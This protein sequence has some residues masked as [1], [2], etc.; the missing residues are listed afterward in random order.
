MAKTSPLTLVLLLIAG[1]A[2]LAFQPLAYAASGHIPSLNAKVTALRFFETPYTMVPREKREYANRFGKGEVRFIGW[3]LSLEFPSPGRQVDFP[4]EQVWYRADGTVF[5][6]QT[7]QTHMEAAWTSSFHYQSWGWNNR[8]NWPAGAYRVDLYVGG[9]KAASGSF[10]IV[11]PPNDAIAAY[12]QGNALSR[13]E[14]YHEAIPAYDRA[15]R[16]YPQYAEAYNNRCVAYD[17][18]GKQD[19]AI[20][21]CNRAIQIEPGYADAYG[22]RGAIYSRKG[23]YDQAIADSSKAIEINPKDGLAYSNRGASFYE[24]GEY[25][26]AWQDVTKAQQLGH[27]VPLALLDKL[28]KTGQKSKQLPPASKQPTQQVAADDSQEIT[29]LVARIN[30]HYSR[31]ALEFHW[32]DDSFN[33]DGSIRKGHAVALEKDF[34]L[35]ARYLECLIP[36]PMWRFFEYQSI[37]ADYCMSANSLGDC[38]NNRHGLKWEEKKTSI[39]VA[40][41]KPLSIALPTN[42]SVSFGYEDDS[43]TN[44]FI[45]CKDRNACEQIATDLKKLV[46]IARSS[47][48]P[49]TTSSPAPKPKTAAEPRQAQGNDP[50]EIPRLVQRISQHYKDTLQIHRSSGD[51]FDHDFIIKAQLVSLGEN[52]MLL[53]RYRI[54]NLGWTVVFDN[55][56]ISADSVGDCDNNRHRLK[57]EEETEQVPLIRIKPPSI[58]VLE[59]DKGV[60]GSNLGVS[61]DYEDYSP[62][63]QPDV[64][65]EQDKYSIDID[66]NSGQSGARTGA[67]ANRW[68]QT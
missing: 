61:F 50:Q 67:R 20:A 10:K 34:T 62:K 39:P 30:Q 56:Q 32:P 36:G 47:T 22:N 63:V 45:G 5:A 17:K 24:K 68:R 11:A 55:Y 14:K 8:G 41:L 53:V 44:R 18:L 60:S 26:K 48:A 46:E 40:R 52:F 31:D 2:G 4:I 3:E 23:Q 54:C 13:V 28:R 16:L 38:D 1:A 9:Q 12:N 58:K 59:I 51:F 57:W 35:V 33:N 43:E 15:I 19:Q 7:L 64:L 65:S 29:R 49:Q 6:R 42:F 25:D 37:P 21:D 66:S 27:Q